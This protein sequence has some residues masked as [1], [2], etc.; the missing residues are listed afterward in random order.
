M[1][2]S[3]RAM[4]L[5][6]RIKSKSVFATPDQRILVPIADTQEIGQNKTD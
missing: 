1:L 4:S 2:I 5:G 6:F 3:F